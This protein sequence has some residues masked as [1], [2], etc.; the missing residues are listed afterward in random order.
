M[1]WKLFRAL[2]WATD[3]TKPALNKL[4]ALLFAS[5]TKRLHI[6]LSSGYVGADTPP[7][8]ATYIRFPGKSDPATLWPNTTWS[9]ISS[10]TLLKG[11]GLRVEGDYAT[12]RGA[13]AYGSTQDD[14]MQSHLHGG[15]PSTDG[16]G[17]PYTGY[18]GGNGTQWGGFNV[19]TPSS[20]GTNG[21]PRTGNETRMA[22][23]TVQVWQRTA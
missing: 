21:T 9:N 8:G 3:S 16:T 5:D 4:G 10:E 22:N 23:V 17:T 18:K 13:A 14:Q 15:A 7:V 20:D 6:S 11:R 2:R 1:G 12:G 19:T